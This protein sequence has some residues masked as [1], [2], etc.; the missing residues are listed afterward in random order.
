VS[1]AIFSVFPPIAVIELLWI[2]L[3]M[4]AAMKPLRTNIIAV[5]QKPTVA[6]R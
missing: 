4:T 3:L 2:R 1:D 6:G 5:L